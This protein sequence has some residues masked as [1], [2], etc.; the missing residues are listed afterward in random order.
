MVVEDSDT[1]LMII[2]EAFQDTAWNP[3]VITARNGEEAMDKLRGPNANLEELPNLILL[4]INMP[5]KNGLDVLEEIKKDRS[6][7]TIPVIILTTSTEEKDVKQAYANHANAYIRKPLDFEE[8][9]ST[10][11]IIEKFWAN[12]C[13]PAP[14]PPSRFI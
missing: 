2:K 1:D 10:L 13:I 14:L 4:D 6:L 12:L 3:K 7:L 8:F 5:R 11:E 9:E